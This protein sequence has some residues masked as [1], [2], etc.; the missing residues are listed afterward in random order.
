MFV[1][2]T[3]MYKYKEDIKNGSIVGRQ[4]ATQWSSLAVIE[5][6]EKKLQKDQSIDLEKTTL[7]IKD[8]KTGSTY[9]VKAI[10][11]YIIPET[12]EEFQAYKEEVKTFLLDKTDEILEYLEETNEQI[13]NPKNYEVHQQSRELKE[14]IEKDPQKI[15]DTIKDFL[16]KK[17][18]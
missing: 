10:D 15:M 3:N 17:V 4:V 18:S 9:N 6:Y 2:Q 5:S 12:K 13:F 1:L 14:Q 7:Y 11:A 16:L 8:I